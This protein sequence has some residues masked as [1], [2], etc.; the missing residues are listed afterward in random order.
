MLVVVEDESASGFATVVTDSQLQLK[1]VDVDI[2]VHVLGP[3]ER[4]FD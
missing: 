4:F 3:R 1:P 2:Y